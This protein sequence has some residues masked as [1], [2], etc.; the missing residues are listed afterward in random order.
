MAYLFDTTLT[1]AEATHIASSV[2]A[3]SMAGANGTACT[4]FALAM[5]CAT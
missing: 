3:V 2:A 5:G 4:E 1:P